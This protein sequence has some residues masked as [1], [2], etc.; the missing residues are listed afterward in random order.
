MT[1]SAPKDKAQKSLLMAFQLQ[2]RRIFVFGGGQVALSRVNSVLNAG[3]AEI[4]VRSLDV[5]DEIKE[6]TKTHNEVRYIDNIDLKDAQFDVE[7]EDRCDLMFACITD[8]AVSEKLAHTFRKICPINCADI[9]DLCDFYCGSIV[10]RGPLEVL[11]STN[12]NAPRLARRIRQDIEG[13][14][15]GTNM[16]KAVE[17]VGILRA[18]LRQKHSGQDKESIKTR[19]KWLSDVCD[20]WSFNQLGSLDEADFDLLLSQYPNHV[21]HD[22]FLSIAKS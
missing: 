11:V 9:P 8:R 21:S 15:D 14:I 4:L 20:S 17:K 22:Q 19:M 5:C 12:G 18:K 7:N 13:L 3:A 16:Q 1:D 2:G 10:K 6:L